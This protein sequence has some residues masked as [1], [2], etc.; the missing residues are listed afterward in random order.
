[1]AP[2]DGILVRDANG[3]GQVTANEMVFS[4]GGSDLQGLAQF[5]TNGDGKLDA[6]DA[7]FSQFAVWQDS[8]SNGVVDPGEMKSLTSLGIT[9][10]SL[11]SN[12][13]GY[14]AADGDVSVVGTGSVSYRDGSTGVLADAMFAT[15]GRTSEGLRAASL[16]PSNPALLGAVAAAGLM[17]MPA[18]AQLPAM[19][20]GAAGAWDIDHLHVPVQPVSG[21]QAQ[22]NHALENETAVPLPDATA[23]AQSSEISVA[24]PQRVQEQLDFAGHEHQL[25]QLGDLLA[26]T[27]THSNLPVAQPFAA[28]HPGAGVSAEMLQAAMAGIAQH[29][30]ANGS[31]TVS[32]EHGQAELGQVLADA[33]HAGA[34]EKPDVDSLLNAIHDPAHG[35]S[36]SSVNEALAML[37]SMGHGHSATPLENHTLMAMHETM[38]MHQVAAPPA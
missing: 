36:H 22:Q 35:Q 6:A 8:N 33:L 24:H 11:T 29:N 15:G 16:L 38:V 14:S 2:Q 37:G 25:P 32:P 26:S 1:V 19:A 34:A 31:A 3:D 30:G 27:G 21:E 17:A 13:I 18:H 28:I 12:G 5:D 7:D 9:S 4:T 20:R 10:I 23:A